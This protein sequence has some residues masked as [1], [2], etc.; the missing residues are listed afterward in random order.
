MTY[1]W[2]FAKPPGGLEAD[3]LLGNAD[4]RGRA[5]GRLD[6]VAGA[7]QQTFLLDGYLEHAAQGR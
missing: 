4:L 2:F 6:P 1:F 5:H 7:G 3:Q